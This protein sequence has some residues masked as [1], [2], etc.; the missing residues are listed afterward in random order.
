VQTDLT[1]LQKEKV[2]ISAKNDRILKK[3]SYIDG[4]GKDNETPFHEVCMED[5]PERNV[6]LVNT[7]SIFKNV[8]HKYLRACTT[9][10]QALGPETYSV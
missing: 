4:S 10:C 7:V 9:M 8:I 6:L 1:K 3:G 2:S 5:I